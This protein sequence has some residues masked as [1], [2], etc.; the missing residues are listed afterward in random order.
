MT[1]IDHLIFWSAFAFAGFV[2]V[3]TWFIVF[4]FAGL[5]SGKD[6]GDK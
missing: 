2:G 6:G 1:D 4:L 3:S 5:F